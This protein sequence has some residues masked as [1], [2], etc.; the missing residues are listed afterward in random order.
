MKGMRID[1]TGPKVKKSI[2]CNE[3]DD[4]RF[5]FPAEYNVYVR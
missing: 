5:A 3:E 2:L 4:G 1:F